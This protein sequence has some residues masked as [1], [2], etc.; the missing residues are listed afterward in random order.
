MAVMNDNTILRHKYF[1]E[2]SFGL[3]IIAALIGISAG[4]GVSAYQTLVRK[5]AP[6]FLQTVRD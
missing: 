5:T 6:F 2:S 3:L 4:L 1:W